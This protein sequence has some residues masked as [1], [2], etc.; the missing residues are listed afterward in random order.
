LDFLIFGGAAFVIT[1]GNYAGGGITDGS[2]FG[3]NPGATR[4]SVSQDGVTFYELNPALAPVVDGLFPTDGAGNF[5]QPVNPALGRA[6]FAGRDLAGLRALYAGSGGGTGYDLAWARDALGARAY[7]LEISYVRVAVLSDRSEIDAFAAVWPPDTTVFHEDFSGEPAARGWRWFGHSNLFVWHPARQQLEV[8][9]DSRQPNSY[10]YRPLGVI[11]GK[12]DDFVLQ[13]DLRLDDITNGV[14]PGKTF[15]FEL[16]LGFQNSLDATNSAY[17]RGAGAESPNLVEFNYFADTGYGATVW[18]AFISTNGQ[19]DFDYAYP[20]S[21]YTLLDLPLG[22]PLHLCLSYAASNRTLR[23]TL[24]ANGQPL[25]PL[26]DTRLTTNFTDFRVDTLAIS[27]YSDAGAGG[28]LLAHGVV[29]NLSV[30]IPA[31]PVQNFIGYRSGGW[32][33]GQFNSRTNWS[34][35]LERATRLPQWTSL[36]PVVPGNGSLLLLTDPKPP[37]D[38]AFYR[39]HAIRP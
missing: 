30:T 18:P 23:T 10:F 29:D 17:R 4:V 5:Q 7:L 35:G 28:S 38:Q 37:L 8:T 27:S 34:Y 9:W 3:H 2:L 25:G 24:L 22:V 14:S 36:A 21:S 39:V 33:Q 19:L 1:N 16:A 20:S 32:W 6:D 12:D 15:A 11:L 26:N 13:F 31:A